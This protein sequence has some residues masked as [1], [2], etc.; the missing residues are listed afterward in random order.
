MFNIQCC[1]WIVIGYGCDSTSGKF[2]M[3]L[4]L[5]R[6]CFAE[7]AVF[8]QAVRPGKF[9]VDRVGCCLVGLEHLL[10]GMLRKFPCRYLPNQGVDAC[11]VSRCRSAQGCARLLRP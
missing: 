4:P 11:C 7:P 10:I 8:P 9:L 6:Q 5:L 3:E 2:R 1:L